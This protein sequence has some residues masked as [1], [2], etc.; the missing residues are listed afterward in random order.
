MPASNDPTTFEL[1]DRSRTNISTASACERDEAET[2][3]CV[4]VVRSLRTSERRQ[5]S[6]E[7]ADGRENNGGVTTGS[8]EPEND[9]GASREAAEE[10]EEPQ[11]AGN[12]PHRQTPFPALDHTASIGAT[13]SLRN[14]SPLHR[15]W[16]THIAL[17][18]P[19]TMDI[20]D[21]LALE[22]THLAHIRT[23]IALAMLSALV[24]QLWHI[25]S[26]TKSS[27]TTSSPPEPLQRFLKPI[28]VAL[29]LAAMLVAV[30]GGWR[31]VR[32]QKGLVRG[33]AV[34]GG[35]D[36]VGV[37]GGV[38]GVITIVMFVASAV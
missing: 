19:A 29:A 15:W 33:K 21:H 30:E 22:R 38:V 11:E 20:R 2:L 6:T 36:M 16:R 12:R 32:M 27:G 1:A 7:G 37:E 34:V 26:T 5:G 13:S 9:T 14:T 31:F 25:P 28:A 23:S 10:D 8:T 4:E 3:P 35:W 24:A 18:V 17:T